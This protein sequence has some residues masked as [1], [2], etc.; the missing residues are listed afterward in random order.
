MLV[1]AP[2][3]AAEHHVAELIA[4][5]LDGAGGLPVEVGVVGGRRGELHAEHADERGVGAQVEHRQASAGADP[6][7]TLEQAAGG[8]RPLALLRLP[9]LST[10]QGLPHGVEERSSGSLAMPPRRGWHVQ[11]VPAGADGS[12]TCF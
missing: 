9:R 10:C 4:G 8:K 7:G 1:I 11:I 5:S 6:A 3:S 12:H 2:V